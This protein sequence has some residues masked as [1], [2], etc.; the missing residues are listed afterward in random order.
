LIIE[1]LPKHPDFRSDSKYASYKKVCVLLE[2]K[3]L[4][5]IIVCSTVLALVTCSSSVTASSSLAAQGLH[6]QQLLQ[7]KNHCLPSS[8]VVL[9]YDGTKR[10][11]K[12]C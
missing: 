12:G 1:T 11:A 4:T 2:T 3:R 8:A 6:A 9:S 10:L 5:A 7:Q